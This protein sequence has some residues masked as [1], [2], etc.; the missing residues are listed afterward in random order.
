MDQTHIGYRNWQQPPSNS[1]PAVQELQLKAE[2][3]MGVAI[4]G[5]T[6][7]WPGSPAKP[8]LPELDAFNR[9]RRFIDVFNRGRNPFKFSVAAKAPWIVLSDR[10]GTVNEEKRIWVNVDWA[11][12]PK[13][14][15]TGAV[16]ISGPGGVAVTVDVPVFNPSTPTRDSLEGFVE[17]GGVV[18]IE[19]EHYTGITGAGPVHWDKID[20][21]GRT[22]SSMTI[23][24]VT[25]ESVAPPEHSPRLE[26]RMYLFDTGKVE[27]TSIIA[28]SLNFVPGRGLRFAVSFD[29]DPPQVVTA[30]PK[31]FFVDNGN[32]NWEASVRDNCREIKSEHTIAKPGYHTLKF[33]MVDPGV[34]LQKLVIDLGGVKPSYFG[35]PES[36]SRRWSGAPNLPNGVKN[37][38]SQ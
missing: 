2:P 18:S 13:G 8:T 17:A 7:A 6:D 33:W 11:K 3:A 36:Y 34:V 23:F 14:N 19:A 21:Y 37:G 5:C 22:L 24:P 12:A 28:P 1:M 9:Q 15:P 29:D 30:V 38:V 26:Y 32:R 16:K 20:D 10:R 27:V 35:P 25:A 31:D 4:E